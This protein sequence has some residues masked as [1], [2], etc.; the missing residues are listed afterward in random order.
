[1]SVYKRLLLNNASWVKEKQTSEPDYFHQLSQPQHPPFLY[2]GCS[3]SRL[4]IDLFTG[5]NPGE[6]FIHRNIANQIF[7]N[8]MNFLSVLE[9]AVTVLNV[10][11]IIVC[12]HYNCGGVEAAYTGAATGL[13]KNWVMNIRDLALENKME[14]DTYTDMQSRLNRLSELNVIRQVRQLCKTSIMTEVFHSGNYPKIHGWVLD[15]YRGAIKELV[16]PIAEWKQY[17]LLPADYEKI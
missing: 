4:P 10:E 13:T 8:D 17:G 1:M 5:A 7:L 12:G 16:L 11:H 9:Y 14:L 3:D 15:I 6:I 2:L